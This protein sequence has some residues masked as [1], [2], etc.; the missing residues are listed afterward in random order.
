MIKTVYV[1]NVLAIPEKGKG[2]EIKDIS[3]TNY[4]G[5]AYTMHSSDDRQTNS[6]QTDGIK[7]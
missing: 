7:Q 6:G 5:R 4:S 1:L 3:I 2:F